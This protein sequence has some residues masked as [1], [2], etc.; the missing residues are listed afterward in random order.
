MKKIVLYFLLVPLF[1]SCSTSRLVNDW[2][3][4]DTDV[5]EANKV[6]VVGM[7]Q[8]AELRRQ[9]EGELSSELE[10]HD[11]ISVRSID[12]FEDSFTDEK[13]S[14]EELNVVEARL[15]EAGFDAILFSKVIGVEEKVSTLQAMRDLTDSFQTF[16][17]DYY[18]SQEIYYTKNNFEYYKLYHAETNLYCIC[19]GKK[20]ELLWT[21]T[22]DIVENQNRK[23]SV[24]D[25][26]KTLISVLRNQQLLIVDL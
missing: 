7:A 20:R 4:P 24:R 8:D 26:V 3:S 23:K 10:K 16:K 17:E 21:G 13:K 6:L 18:R 19:P 22:I 2:K 1:L 5:F 14:E 11:V 12:F 9:F 15:L 25:Y